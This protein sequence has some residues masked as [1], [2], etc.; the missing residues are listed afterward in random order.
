MYKNAEPREYTLGKTKS[1]SDRQDR[2]LAG[3]LVA[4]SAVP[5]VWNG[6]NNSFSPVY[7][8]GYCWRCGAQCAL[9]HPT[10][11]P[12]SINKTST[13]EPEL[14]VQHSE[15]KKPQGCWGAMPRGTASLALFLSPQEFWIQIQLPLLLLLLANAVTSNPDTVA[16][17]S[18]WL[19]SV[20]D[21]L[22][23]WCLC[24]V[25]LRAGIYFVFE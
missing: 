2:F 5:S 19:L 13:Y 9:Q 23:I 6:A 20:N 17:S 1:T 25:Q 7:M 21:V 15:I 11:F 14:K 24:S 18:V 4:Y 22:S 12:L 16:S 10:L 8:R 3:S